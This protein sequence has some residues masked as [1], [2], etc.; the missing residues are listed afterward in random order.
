MDWY[1]RH[2]ALWR[3]KTMELNPFQGLRQSWRRLSDAAGILRP[4]FIPKNGLLYHDRCDKILTEQDEKAK[5]RSEKSRKGATARW[6][7]NNDIDAT[8][9]PQAKLADAK[10]KERTE[11]NRTVFYSRR[12]LPH[13][14][15]TER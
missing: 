6:H 13:T 15:K 4:F 10:G 5:T 9:I 3:A 8:G 12:R 7:K 2:I 1:P 11:Q 14:P